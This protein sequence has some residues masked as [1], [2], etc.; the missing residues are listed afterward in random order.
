VNDELVAK[1][2]GIFRISNQDQ[3]TNPLNLDS[4][5]DD[6]YLNLTVNSKRALQVAV[7][8]LLTE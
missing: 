5:I 8:D 3:T 6:V 1:D 2:I 4:R 7:L